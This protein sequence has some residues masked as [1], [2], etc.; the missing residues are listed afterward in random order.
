MAIC[1]TLNHPLAPLLA[2]YSENY[3]RWALFLLFKQSPDQEF[4]NHSL[5][6]DHQRISVWCFWCAL[7]H[8]QNV[9]CRYDLSEVQEPKVLSAQTFS[10]YNHHPLLR[11]DIFLRYSFVPLF[12]R[13]ILWNVFC[14]SFYPVHSLYQQMLPSFSTSFLYEPS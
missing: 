3:L 11:M 4:L 6:N 8:S 9:F 5:L 2:L 14:Y 10:F 12:F 1:T 7:E 13:S